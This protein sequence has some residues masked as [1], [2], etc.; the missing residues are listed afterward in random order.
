[1]KESKGERKKD[2]EDRSIKRMGRRRKGEKTG[3]DYGYSSNIACI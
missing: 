1:V 2:V 3:L